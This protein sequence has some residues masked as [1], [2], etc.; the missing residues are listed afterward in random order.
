MVRTPNPSKNGDKNQGMILVDMGK[1]MKLPLE[2][3]SS[4]NK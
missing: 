4:I 3:Q 2:T 1:K